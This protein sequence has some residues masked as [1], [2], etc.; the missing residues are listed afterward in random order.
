[1]PLNR[2]S[3]KEGMDSQ[4]CWENIAEGIGS[5]LSAPIDIW[6]HHGWRAVRQVACKPVKD[7]IDR[8]RGGISGGIFH[9]HS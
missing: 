9:F 2:R 5:E 6:I 1:M 8:S 7:S 4:R 3:S